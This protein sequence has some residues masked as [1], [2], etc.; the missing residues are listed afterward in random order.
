MLETMFLI[1]N[2]GL[3]Q[4]NAAGFFPAMLGSC[5]HHSSQAAPEVTRGH[6]RG[7]GQDHSMVS[8]GAGLRAQVTPSHEVLSIV[9]ID[10]K[11]L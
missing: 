4:R 2:E 8:S 11:T 7:H 10:C 6:A 5:H 1:L 3:P 9:D